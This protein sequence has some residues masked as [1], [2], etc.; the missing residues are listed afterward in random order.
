MMALLYGK[1]VSTIFNSRRAE[2]WKGE[3]QQ[4]GHEDRTT[5]ESRQQLIRQE[6]IRILY[7]NRNSTMWTDGL[8]NI[9]WTEIELHRWASPFS[10]FAN[11]QLPSVS[12]ETN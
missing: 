11:G 4:F 6:S 5:W 12:S 9:G 1:P 8:K 2:F 7:K 3:L 10:P